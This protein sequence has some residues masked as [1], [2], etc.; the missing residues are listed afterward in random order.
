MTLLKHVADVRVSNVDKKS[1][2]GEKPV[3]LCNY[4]DVYYGDVLTA[5]SNDYMAATASTEQIRSFRLRPGDT[6]LTKDSETADDIGVSAFIEESADDLVCG[7]HLAIVRPRQDAIDP[8]YLS[9]CLRSTAARGQLSTAAT[10]VTRFGLRTD[11][12]ASTVLTT[13]DR[14]KQRGIADFLDE[15]V[16][17]IDLT[18]SARR[19]QARLISERKSSRL[20]KM[21]GDQNLNHR[22]IPLT[23]LLKQPPNYGVLVPK[24]DSAGIPFIRVN[25]LTAL[26]TGQAPAMSIE[27]EQS[28][29]YRR[30]VVAPGDVLTSV[31]GTLG[32]SAIVP[33]SAAG[34]NIARAVCRLQPAPAVAPWF[35]LGWLSSPQFLS[36]AER[37]T[38][39]GAAQATLN[40]SD[41]MKFQVAVPADGNF[42]DAG[43][44]IEKLFDEFSIT[45]SALQRG[46]KL[47]A[48]RK[49]ALI[50]AAVTGQ[51]DVTTARSGLGVDVP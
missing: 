2:D 15:Q 28:L 21:F 26:A 7:Y 22:T 41:I 39:G 1:Y 29:E 33:E 47:L 8:K 45:L 35:L 9:W 25:D 3:R 19:R 11:A 27:N 4:T 34:S 49:Q 20:A 6:V 18:L 17:L 12:L 10:G 30:T 46:E 42:F 31:V 16:A 50:T 37:A 38:G 43:T 13:P 40:M 44:K 51:L 23:H 32:Q 5:S 24:F 14:H 36:D 48:E